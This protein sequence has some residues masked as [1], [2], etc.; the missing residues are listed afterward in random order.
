MALQIILIIMNLE[1]EKE[2]ELFLGNMAIKISLVIFYVSLVLILM[3]PLIMK[4]SFKDAD[5]FG[6]REKKKLFLG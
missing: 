6:N 5:E 3:I 1:R 2:M 4:Y